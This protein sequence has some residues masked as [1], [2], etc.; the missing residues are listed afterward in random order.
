MYCPNCGTKISMEQKYCRSCGLGLEK[1]A[2]SLVEQLPTKLAESLQAQKD[3]IERWGVVALSI[4][5]VGVL[6]IPLYRVVRLLLEGRILAGLGL[7]ALIAVLACGVLSVI[8]FAKAKEVEEAK[9]KRR[10][11]QAKELP[12]GSAA[13]RLL[14]EGHLE[15]IPSV[16]DGTTELLYAESKNAAQ[17]S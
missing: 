4:F 14:P 17:E 5:G 2:Q 12:G 13:P 16:T 1:I 8:L 6:S 9:T 11:E 15:P 7:L 3:K 10:A